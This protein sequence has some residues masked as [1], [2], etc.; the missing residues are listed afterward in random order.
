MT[1]TRCAHNLPEPFLNNRILTVWCG[2]A[3]PH[4]E[5]LRLQAEELRVA[6]PIRPDTGQSPRPSS[7][8]ELTETEMNE[9]EVK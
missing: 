5:L 7:D 2:P 4:E 3:H 1:E 8:R 6:E 9:L